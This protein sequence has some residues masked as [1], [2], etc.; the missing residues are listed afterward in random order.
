MKAG[1]IGQ[2]V[3]CKIV[4]ILGLEN[5]EMAKLIFCAIPAIYIT[6]ATIIGSVVSMY[7][8]YV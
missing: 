8:T 3:I 6:C 7:T 2:D 4:N 5:A 1:Q